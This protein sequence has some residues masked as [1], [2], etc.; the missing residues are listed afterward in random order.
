MFGTDAVHG[1]NNVPAA[2]LYPHNLG[3]GAAFDP[4]LTREVAWRPRRTCAP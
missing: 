3:L 2:T 4:A 1:V